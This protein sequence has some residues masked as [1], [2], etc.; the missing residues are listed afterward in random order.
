MSTITTKD[1]TRI[2]YKDWGSGQPVVAAP[3][4]IYTLLDE[5]SNTVLSAARPGGQG[6]GQPVR[7][8]AHHADA[9]PARGVFLH[10]TPGRPRRA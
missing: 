1:G 9:G 7:S 6:R 3:D 2:N 4:L 5:T 10:R 8:P